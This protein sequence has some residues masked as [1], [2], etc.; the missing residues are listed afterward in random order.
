[1]FYATSG[2]CYADRHLDYESGRF[3]EENTYEKEEIEMND[4]I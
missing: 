2:K 1:M 3:S 4:K